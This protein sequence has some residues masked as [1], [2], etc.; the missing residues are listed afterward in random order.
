MSLK[1]D[2]KRDLNKEL[3]E[4]FKIDFKE[5]KRLFKDYRDGGDEIYDYGLWFSYEVEDKEG[6]FRWLL[7]WGGPSTEFRFFTNPDLTIRRIEYVFMDWYVR[8]DYELTGEEFKVLEEIY[9]E[10]FKDSGACEVALKEYEREE[11]EDVV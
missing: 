10:L 9:N 7:S 11:D 1:K 6:F 8:T 5:L 4:H 3:K 2:E